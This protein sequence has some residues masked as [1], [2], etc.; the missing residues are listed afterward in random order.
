MYLIYYRI[1]ALYTN[2]CQYVSDCSHR[3]SIYCPH[4]SDPFRYSFMRRNVRRLNREV[5]QITPIPTQQ[6]NN[7]INGM[8]TY[9]SST[10]NNPAVKPA[11]VPI[12]R[13]GILADTVTATGPTIYP[14]TSVLS[15]NLLTQ[16][17]STSTGPSILSAYNNQTNTNPIPTTHIQ[18]NTNTTLNTSQ[19]TTQNTTDGTRKKTSKGPVRKAANLAELRRYFKAAEEAANEVINEQI[20][21][22]Q[23]QALY[24]N[25]SSNTTDQNNTN[26]NNMTEFI[27]TSNKSVYSPSRL[28]ALQLANNNPIFRD[29]LKRKLAES[30]SNITN[31]NMLFKDGQNSDLKEPNFHKRTNTSSTSYNTSSSSAHNDDVYN[32]NN[33]DEL[34]E[35]TDINNNKLLLPRSDLKLIT[36]NN[37]GNYSILLLLNF[38]IYYHL[39]LYVCILHPTTCNMYLTLFICTTNIILYYMYVLYVMCRYKL[40]FLYTRWHRIYYRSTRY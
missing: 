8:K 18:Y 34:I 5:G 20:Q 22:T 11:T 10:T 37:T 40:F 30:G 9:S 35:V 21:Q 3:H 14:N 25:N 4:N 23:Q 29:K 1:G 12:N 2:L 36:N 31:T 15:S 6:S 27:N 19:N 16:S 32:N 39:H 24:T 7:T 33:S 38:F 28:I 26:T 17:S 13:S